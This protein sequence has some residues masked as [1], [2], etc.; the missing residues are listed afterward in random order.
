MKGIAHFVSGVAIA[1][2]FPE[3][4]HGAVQNLAFGPV[5]GGIA[6]LLPDTLDFKF[7][8]CFSRR[9]GEVDPAQ[10]LD[11]SGSPD[12]QAIAGQIVAAIEQAHR[13]DRPI[14][15]QLHTVRLGA[16]LWRQ[17][18]VTLDAPH[19]QVIVSL[20]PVVTTS[21][22]P[23]TGSEIG[24]LEPG[25][26][27]S[28]VPILLTGDPEVRIDL[29]SGPTLA[30]QKVGE[31]VEVTFLP[32]HRRWTHSLFMVLLLGALGWLVAPVYGLVMALAVLTHIAEDQMGCMGSDL[33]FPLGRKRV[34]GL[35]WFSSGDPTANFLTVWIGLSVIG[36]NLDRFSQAPV[37]PV[38]PYLLGMIVAPTLLLLG[39]S[40]WTA[41]WRPRRAAKR[42]VF[43]SSMSVGEWLDETAEMDV[44]S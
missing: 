15:L 32:W 23:L 12:P 13:S 5:L 43:T 16:D 6:G 44:E 22:E 31:G 11:A 30:F 18:S 35:R 8:R 39:V 41:W 25:R 17:W 14:H 3:V 28:P 33:F 24:S 34:P 38:M 20:G 4:V 10:M 37:L 19:N 29:F 27:P 2:F 36:L 40:Q 42:A 1:T 7:V 9:D 21:G 26:A